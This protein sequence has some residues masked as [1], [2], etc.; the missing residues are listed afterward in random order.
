MCVQE[1]CL[2][3]LTATLLEI[4]GKK[5]KTVQMS[6]HKVNDKA[7]L[8]NRTVY[9]NENEWMIVTHFNMDDC[10]EHN[11]AVRKEYTQFDAIYIK[12]KNV[13]R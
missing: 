11:I 1:T 6:L 7:M 13:Q 9:S 5:L 2:K 4:G 3:T 10:Q 12:F 8:H